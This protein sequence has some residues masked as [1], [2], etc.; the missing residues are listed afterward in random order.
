MNTSLIQVS[1]NKLAEI[2]Q[3]IKGASRVNDDGKE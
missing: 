3:Y 1:E 2:R